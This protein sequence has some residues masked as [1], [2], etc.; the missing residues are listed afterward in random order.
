MNILIGHSYIIE[1][2]TDGKIGIKLICMG[3]TPGKIITLIRKAPFGGAYFIACEN[4]RIGLSENELNS[5]DLSAI[6]N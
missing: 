6:D 4:K 1:E 3:I 5:I 2:V